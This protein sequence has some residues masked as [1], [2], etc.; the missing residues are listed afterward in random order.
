MTASSPPPGPGRV[1]APRAA[2]RP[3]VWTP[4]GWAFVFLGVCLPATIFFLLVVVWLVQT[5]I[6]SG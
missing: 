6:G 5:L 3:S 2:F 4:G 1:R